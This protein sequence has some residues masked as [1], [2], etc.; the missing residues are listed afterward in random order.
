MVF[1]RYYLHSFPTAGK[2]PHW[3]EEPQNLHF[4]YLESTLD[5]C[6][7]H[8]FSLFCSFVPIT[9]TCSFEAS[10]DL[11][12]E[13]A[14]S[15]VSLSPLSTVWSRIL[16]MNL[17]NTYTTH[18][19]TFF[20]SNVQ[21]TFFSRLAEAVTYICYSCLNLLQFSDLFIK[22]QCTRF[23]KAAHV[24]TH[25]S[26]TKYVK[27]TMEQILSRSKVQVSMHA[28]SSMVLTWFY[29]YNFKICNS[30]LP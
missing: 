8:G 20:F 24:L 27:I 13:I 16:N 21:Q 17:L 29:T 19:F 7:C 9:F 26:H 23:V 25:T 22:T 30:S 1:F 4:F 10:E 5:A 15:S 14:F 11:P 12:I 3:W 28:K 6:R 18:D 2:D